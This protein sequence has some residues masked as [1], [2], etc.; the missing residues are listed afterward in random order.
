MS[1]LAE[2]FAKDIQLLSHSEQYVFYYVDGHIDQVAEWT[3]TKLADTLSTS[4]TTIIRMCKKLGLDGYSE[5]RYMLRDLQV[6]VSTDDTPDIK[7]EY[8]QNFAQIVQ[9]IQLPDIEFIASKLLHAKT[10]IVVSVGL[11]KTIGE[12]LGKRLIQVQKPTM[13]AYESHII[14]LLP[15][16]VKANDVVLFISMS[17]DTKTLVQAAKK[18]QYSNCYMFSITNHGDSELS[19]LMTE[20]IYS[21]IPTKSYAGYDITSRSCLMIQIDLLFEVYLRKMLAEQ[22]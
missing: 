10:I 8:L 19:K 6:P 16:F 5:F 9:N 11:T 14:D 1:L 2:K 3:L 12:Y 7:E 18:L 15:S 4:N 21:N 13:Y 22:K 17:G 20:N